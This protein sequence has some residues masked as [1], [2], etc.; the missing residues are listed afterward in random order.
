MNWVLFRQGDNI[1]FNMYSFI[2]LCNAHIIYW[3][4]IQSYQWFGLLC[5]YK[6]YVIIHLLSFGPTVNSRFMIM[7]FQHC[8]SVHIIVYKW[9]QFQFLLSFYCGLFGLHWF[10]G[11]IIYFN[12]GIYGHTTNVRRKSC[13]T[14]IFVTDVSFIFLYITYCFLLWILQWND[15]LN[16]FVFLCTYVLHIT[17]IA[18]N[19]YKVGIP[20][21]P[22]Y[23]FI[24]RGQNK[25]IIARSTYMCFIRCQSLFNLC[26]L[27]PSINATK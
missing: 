19:K 24:P 13:S 6:I 3:I 20:L 18:A 25:A 14:L 1:L 5:T 8:K 12:A 10:R 11:L 16:S 23:H 26:E 7:T 21:I 17:Y 15:S 27:S 2:Y 9:M 4:H 22:V